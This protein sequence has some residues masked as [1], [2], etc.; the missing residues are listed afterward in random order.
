MGIVLFGSYAFYEHLINGYSYGQIVSS[1]IPLVSS[2]GNSLS[3]KAPADRPAQSA[4]GPGSAST[5]A[6]TS[7]AGPV[8]N[9]AVGTPQTG[10]GT[11]GATGGSGSSGS[12][13]SG[14]GSTQPVSSGWPGASN[15]GWQPTGAVLTAYTGPTKITADGTVISGQDIS[16]CLTITASNVT[17]K[18][19]R[20]RCSGY[21]VVKF[22]G[23]NELIED[24]ELDGMGS[25]TV[26]PALIGANFKAYRLNIHGS[27]D[28]IHPGSNALVQDSWVHD[29]VQANGSHNDAIQ[30]WNVD[31]VTIR[32]NYLD[33]ANKETSCILPSSNDGYIKNVT[34]DNNL[35]NGGGYTVY[36]GGGSGAIYP[37]ANLS[38]TNNRFMRSPTGGHWPK[39]GY[40][41]VKAYIASGDVWSNNVWDDTSQLIP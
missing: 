12:G 23:S 8:N 3:A 40:Y 28:G 1:D 31:G 38:F 24:T 11:S 35:M 19:S 32:H 37:V 30:M 25:S 20:I 2:S 6:S 13:S 36:G 10:E 29:L 26:N 15:T 14:S 17:I 16:G 7:S 4:G 41:G 34:V 22:E 39:G 27:A 33:N 18:D 9:N 5:S 21:W